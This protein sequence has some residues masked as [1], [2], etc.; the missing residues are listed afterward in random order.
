[1]RPARNGGH[2]STSCHGELAWRVTPAN[3]PAAAFA[4]SVAPRTV[5]SRPFYGVTPTRPPA[6]AAPKS[7][8]LAPK[9]LALVAA[10]GG[11][12]LI[13]RELGAEQEYRRRNRQTVAGRAYRQTPRFLMCP[14]RVNPA[15]VL[16]RDPDSV[17]IYSPRQKVCL[18][19]GPLCRQGHRR[20]CPTSRLSHTL[21]PSL[22]APNRGLFAAP[23]VLFRRGAEKT[24]A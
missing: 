3:R 4:F 17:S 24:R 5:L 19:S 9:V 8:R 15:S 14:L 2:R 1:M 6:G 18:F 16:W 11:Y 20:G 23:P 10:G 7:D 21:Q 13:G 22:C 12:R